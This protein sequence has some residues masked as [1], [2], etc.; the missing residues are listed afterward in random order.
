MHPKQCANGSQQTK[1]GTDLVEVSQISLVLWV[2]GSL[3]MAGQIQTMVE[4]GALGPHSLRP[5]CKP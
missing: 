3:K 5:L 1:K 2:S 4:P